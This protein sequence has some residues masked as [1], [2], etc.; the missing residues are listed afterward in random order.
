MVLNNKFET[1]YNKFPPEGSVPIISKALVKSQLS[2]NFN[3][4]SNLGEDFPIRAAESSIT[5]IPDSKIKG[6]LFKINDKNKLT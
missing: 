3:V 4:I 1:P 6:K 5:P 2:N